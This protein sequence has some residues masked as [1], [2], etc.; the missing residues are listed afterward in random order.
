MKRLE[1]V[2]EFTSANKDRSLKK[3]VLKKNFKFR[4]CKINCV[5]PPLI[6]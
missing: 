3:L 2:E 1:N 5:N 4:D 6:H